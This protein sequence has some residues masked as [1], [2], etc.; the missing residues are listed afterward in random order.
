M[1]ERIQRFMAGMENSKLQK[2]AHDF[3][4]GV[5]RLVGA[6]EVVLRED[7]EVGKRG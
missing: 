3:K 1:G 6:D 5:I 2:G 4:T 7:E